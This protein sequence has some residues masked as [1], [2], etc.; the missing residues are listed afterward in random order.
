MFAAAT[1]HLFTLGC[2]HSAEVPQVVKQLQRPVLGH[3]KCTFSLQTNAP[4]IK[5][6]DFYAHNKQRHRLVE[7]QL[8]SEA[9]VFSIHTTLISQQNRLETWS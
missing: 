1:F 4:P 8:I 6:D 2:E 9:D 7:S 3:W 5:G